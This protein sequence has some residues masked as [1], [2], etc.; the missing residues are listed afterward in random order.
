MQLCQNNNGYVQQLSIYANCNT[1]KTS[2]TGKLVA[3][4]SPSKTNNKKNYLDNVRLCFWFNIYLP[5]VVRINV[6]RDILVFY[7]LP[8]VRSDPGPNRKRLFCGHTIS[9]TRDTGS[10]HLNFSRKWQDR[11]SECYIMKCGANQLSKCFCWFFHVAWSIMLCATDITP[12]KTDE[13]IWSSI[14]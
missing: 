14:R 3:R 9:V 2:I 13:M 5:N 12:W 4:P 1:T 11:I 7:S 8:F 10:T 6:L